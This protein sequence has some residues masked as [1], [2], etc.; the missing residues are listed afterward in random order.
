MGLVF[1]GFIPALQREARFTPR[2][3]STIGGAPL[4]GAVFALGLD[5]VPR[6]DADR[7]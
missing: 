4:L 7:R 6:P 5:A 1:V 2:Q 3:L